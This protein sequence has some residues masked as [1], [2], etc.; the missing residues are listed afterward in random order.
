MK[1]I[2]LLLLMTFLLITAINAQ[3]LSHSHDQ[4]INNGT[5]ACANA[6]EG[7]SHNNSFWRS[8]TLSDFEITT[9]RK[10][11]GA[12]FGLTFIDTG[13]T[14]PVVD[15]TVRLLTSDATFPAGTFTEIA[16]KVVS[17]TAA[18]NL[19]L[20]SVTFDTPPTV[21][22]D[23]EVIIQVEALSG[24]EAIVDVRVG[25]NDLGE[26][27][28][29]YLSSTDCEGIDPTPISELGEFPSSHIVLNLVVENPSASIEDNNLVGVSVYPSPISDVLNITM[30]ANSTIIKAS[31]FDLLGRDTGINITNDTMN[32]SKLAPGIYMFLLETNQG[33]FTTKIVK[34]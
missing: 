15:L 23:T 13:G 14:D 1:K 16:S 19:T 20:I 12:E 27:A 32:T 2:T 3:T 9:D 26:D 31:I 21:T 34:K 8:Y 17:V 28:P 5:V 25:E 7:F 24:E 29:S 18:D 11:L 22:S 6:S 10:V 4:A 33:K 30:P